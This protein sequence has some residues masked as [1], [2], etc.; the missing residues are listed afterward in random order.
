MLST[1]GQI[2]MSGLAYELGELEDI[3]ALSE[4]VGKPEVLENLRALG[5]V[6]YARSRRPTAELA[7]AAIERTLAEAQLQ[8]REVDAVVYA[9]NHFHDR[10]VDKDPIKRALHELG[11]RH[12]YPIG[13]SFSACGNFHTALRV[14]A[15]LIAA[16]GCNTVLV[17]TADCNAEY[18]PESRLYSTNVSV[19]SDAAASCV[20]R[21]EA[22]PQFRWRGTAQFTDSQM[23]ELSDPKRIVDYLACLGNGLERVTCDG[24]ALAQVDR[25]QLRWLITNNYNTSVTRLFSIKTG[26]PMASIFQANL[27]RFAHAY[28][29]DNLI[30]LRDL[31]AAGGLDVGES[32]MLLGSGPNTWSATVLELSAVRGAWGPV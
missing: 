10:D 8:A 9:T 4:L 29:A 19:L 32:V 13:I 18:E 1:R 20:L 30:N 26:F 17:V 27:A 25:S 12:A 6:Q 15:G 21:I 5:L 22:E 23:V 31:L 7:R 2:G 14:G 24:L 28:A 3:G 16:G 11:L